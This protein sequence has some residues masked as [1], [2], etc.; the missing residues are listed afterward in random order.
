MRAALLLRV[1]ARLLD[2]NRRRR[3]KRAER[4]AKNA[5]QLPR[6][7]LGQCLG[8]DEFAE[9]EREEETRA[10]AGRSQ[11]TVV[12]LYAD[13]PEVSSA[14]EPLVGLSSPSVLLIAQ[15]GARER[16]VGL[17]GCVEEKHDVRWQKEMVCRFMLLFV[18][19]LVAKLCLDASFRLLTAPVGNRFWS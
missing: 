3:R 15:E 10:G 14:I 6:G 11:Y 4:C 13:E 9:D 16:E 8:A 2:A 5:A 1:S 19:L 17:Y 12:D 18:M 7:W